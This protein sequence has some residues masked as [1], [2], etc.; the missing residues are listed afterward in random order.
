MA[1]KDQV[2]SELPHLVLMSAAS[3]TGSP[4]DARRGCTGKG[5]DCITAWVMCQ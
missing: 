3:H 4:P 2:V 1:V 5:T